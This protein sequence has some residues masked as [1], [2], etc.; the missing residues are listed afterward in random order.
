MPRLSEYVNTAEAA[1]F[2]GVSQNTVRAWAEVGK[3]PMC[4]SPANGYR[5]FLRRDLDW[6]LAKLARS[7]MH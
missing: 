3:L 7:I 6:F 1:R 5:L 2:L 4:R